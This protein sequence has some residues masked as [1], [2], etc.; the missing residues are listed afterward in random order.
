[1]QLRLRYEIDTPD[2]LRE[3]VHLV[4]GAG[5]FFFDGADAPKGTPAALEIVFTRT[6]QTALLRGVIWARPSSGGVWLELENAEA[7]LER[8]ESSPRRDDL[9]MGSE[10]LVL[11]EGDGHALLCRLSDVSGGGARIGIVEADAGPVGN[12]VR[13]GLPEA[14]PDGLQ[15]VATGRVVW[16]SGREAGVEWDR[17]ALTSRL[18]VRRLLELAAEEWEGARATAHPPECR[19][20]AAALMLGA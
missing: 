16:V 8:L 1:M 2:H 7:C 5:Y 17:S 13:I 14:G 20:Q 11:W 3:H 12:R 4:D 10:Q 18:A 19:Q 6:D 9:R 15:L